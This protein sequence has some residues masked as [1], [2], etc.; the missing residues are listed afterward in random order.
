VKMKVGLV[1]RFS[2]ISMQQSVKQFNLQSCRKHRWNY[3]NAYLSQIL[4]LQSHRIF[5]L[6]RYCSNLI[7]GCIT[8]VCDSRDIVQT[9][10]F[11]VFREK[12]YGTQEPT[13]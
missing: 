1:T 13:R 3:E 7:D 4:Y 11:P 5:K 2:Q 12:L 10:D 6:T 8:L 9:T